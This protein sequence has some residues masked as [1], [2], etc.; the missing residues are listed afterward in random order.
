M[1]SPHKMMF[2][3]I[4]LSSTLIVI[5]SPSWMAMWIGLE[6]NLLS[7]IP[8]MKEKNNSLSSESIIKYFI[9]QALASTILMFSLLNP[10]LNQKLIISIPLF[11]KL[12]LMPFHFWYPMIMEGISWMNC[13]ILLTWQKISPMIILSYLDLNLITTTLVMI[14]N[15]MSSMLSMNFSSLRKV[16][17]FSSLNNLSWMIPLMFISK[18]M[19]M[20]YLT[21]Y[22][23]VSSSIIILLKS[24]NISFMNQLFYLKL[25][26]K[27]NIMMMVSFLSL[28]GLPPFLGFIP[29]W[30]S[31]QEMISSNLFILTTS[32][33]ISTLILIFS[34]SR[35]MISSLLLINNEKSWNKCY[36]YNYTKFS[37]LNLFMII[38]WTILLT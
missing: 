29:K 4:L 9:V 8:L 34:Y 35:L 17:T 11:I 16:M 33:L 1:K 19:W 15:L 10:F 7:F 32:Y 14:T 3:T 26:F 23:I 22:S 2:F 21:V 12:G 6:I 31:I 18:P 24:M 28:A 30:I 27:W 38:P 37:M 36:F 5:S 13:L 25:K 20:I